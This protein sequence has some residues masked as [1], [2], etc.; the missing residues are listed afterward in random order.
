MWHLDSLEGK[1]DAVLQKQESHRE[2]Q[3]VK[4]KGL[5]NM[6]LSETCVG[7][8]YKTLLGIDWLMGLVLQLQ[9]YNISPKP[10]YE[11]MVSRRNIFDFCF[12]G[13]GFSHCIRQRIYEN[14]I[15]FNTI[16]F[17]LQVKETM[18]KTHMLLLTS[19]KQH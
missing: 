18:R 15:E 2:Q 17:E 1:E 4:S 3:V 7:W 13:S 16:S 11:L 10:P 14:Y 8:Q 5:C 12:I 6:S 9:V 19:R